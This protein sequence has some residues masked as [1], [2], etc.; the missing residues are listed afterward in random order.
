MTT[1]S[2]PKIDYTKEVRFAVVMYGGVS[3]AI[4]ING[5]AQELLRMV[6]ATAQKKGNTREA[7]LSNE[8]LSGSERVYR[9]LSHL[10]A[11]N[12]GDTEPA[13]LAADIPTRF[14]VDTITGASAGGI[15][16]IFLAKALVRGQ[17]LNRIQQLWIQEGAI[18]KLLNDRFSTD[19]PVGYDKKPP[20]LLNSK[21]MYFEL[22]KAFD[23][24]DDVKPGLAKSSAAEASEPLIDELDVYVT[25]TDLNGVVLPMRLT[26][27]VIYERRHKNVFHLIYPRE[28]YSNDGNRLPDDIDF[29]PE[30]NPFL[31][32]AARCTSSFPFA[33]EPMVL[34]DVDPVLMRY[35]TYKDAKPPYSETD[36]WRRFFHDYERASGIDHVPPQRRAFADGGDLDNKPFGYAVETLSRRHADCPISRKLLY[37]EPAPDH[38]ED[39]QEKAERPDF[40][41][42]AIDALSTLPMYETIREDLQRLNDRNRLVLRLNRV[43]EN[44]DID[45]DK[46]KGSA[47]NVQELIDDNHKELRESTDDEWSTLYLDDMIKRKGRAYA[48]YHRLEIASVTDDLARV[49]TRG[50]GLSEDSDFFAVYRSFSRAWRG[51]RYTDYRQDQTTESGLPTSV[52]PRPINQFLTNFNLSY[53][54]R[55][56]SFLR[57]RIE[58]LS[59]LDEKKLRD[60]YKWAR[61]FNLT[62]DHLRDFRLELRRIYRELKRIETDLRKVQRH[63]VSRPKP[64]DPKIRRDRHNRIAELSKEIVKKIKGGVLPDGTLNP[65][66][67]LDRFIA[68]TKRGVC[69]SP[70]SESDRRAEAFLRAFPDVWLKICE[71]ADEIGAEVKNARGDADQMC[72]TIL[73]IRSAEGE[74]TKAAPSDGAA[75]AQDCLR[76]YYVNYDDYDMIIFPIMYETEI[77]E[78]A[79]VDV[80][81]ISPEDGTALINER[82]AKCQ[83]LAGTA[84]GH[85][86]AFLE[87]RW[88]EN[89]I[90]WGRLD[91]AERIISSVLPA[92]HPQKPQLI[93][94]A[95]AEIVYETIADMGIEATHDLLCE[96]LMRT[97]S[98]ECDASLLSNSDPKSPG[99]IDKLT[100]AFQYLEIAVDE[101]ARARLD[102]KIDKV[103]LQ[104][105][106]FAVFPKNSRPDPEATLKTAS[107]ATTIVGKMFEKLADDQ[108]SRGKKYAAWVTRLG[109]IAWGMAELATPRSLWNLMFRYWLKLLYAFEI[110]M[111]IGATILAKPQ[112]SQF[113]WTMFGITAAVNT[114]AWLM[115]DHMNYSRRV[116]RF[117]VSVFLLTLVGL[118]AIGGLKTG[119]FLFGWSFKGMTPLGWLHKQLDSL[120]SW[121]AAHLPDRVWTTVRAGWPLIIAFA[122][123]VLLW[124]RARVRNIQPSRKKGQATPPLR[125]QVT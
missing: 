39:V 104:D 93:A 119:S 46:A 17:S 102:A 81:R 50:A 21:R 89:D 94:E 78:P 54:V 57:S 41:E 24:M 118:T 64:G 115:H 33:F 28:N 116:A 61:D 6:R 83:K 44:V 80:F 107:R 105:H 23:G 112:V 121:M 45:V 19:P 12:H 53:P 92:N 48:A 11:D 63:L 27:E 96:S 73:N 103:A 97:V 122:L 42:N 100:E 60:T 82:V 10:L 120:D 25:T 110:V 72:S 65:T 71:I 101:R 18:E 15:N 108:A 98:G 75:Q 8:Q 26:D 113:G 7:L 30:N 14:V 55:R 4:Y 58:I 99:F 68:G 37:V 3:L 90:L 91:G 38:P 70:E 74:E 67:V 16:G 32:Y 76:N 86:G 52:N 66:V 117:V 22:L 31:A 111:I 79:P 95:L 34:E 59:C 87:K 84:L 36:S 88:R 125:Q 56:I 109:L 49:L 69:D 47:G 35:G 124:R 9:K 40:V 106:Y 43:L 85:F 51:M 2:N 5:V 1:P 13:N 123:I 20:A 29:L 114:V 77:G 62:Q